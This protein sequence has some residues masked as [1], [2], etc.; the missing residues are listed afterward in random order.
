MASVAGHQLHHEVPGSLLLIGEKV[1]VLRVG[2][3]LDVYV[4]VFG[5]VLR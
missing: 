3:E 2:G 5:E 1:P 4:S